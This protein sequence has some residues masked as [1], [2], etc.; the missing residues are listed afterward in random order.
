MHNYFLIEHDYS[1][2]VIH[3]FKSE[4]K[5]WINYNVVKIII[6]MIV[7]SEIIIN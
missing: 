1:H 2:Y 4:L 3:N 5:L 7:I 6:V